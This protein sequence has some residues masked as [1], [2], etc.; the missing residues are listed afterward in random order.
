MIHFH[1]DCRLLSDVVVTS[2]PS[3]EG[4]PESLDYLPG[5]KFLGIVAAEL[6]EEKEPQ[7]TLDLFHN[8]K[9]C[10][11]DAHPAIGGKRCLKMPLVWSINK[12]GKL[13]ENDVFQHHSIMSH[14]ALAE[15][16]IQLKQLR[17]SYFQP[18][19][20]ECID[21]KQTFRIKSA[22]DSNFR[23][24]EDKKMYGYYALP[25]GSNW[26]F[27]VSS[28]NETLLELV[29]SKLEGSKRIG[30]SRS[31]EYG[32]VSISFIEKMKAEP[33]NLTIGSHVLYLDSA[34]CLPV[35]FEGHL[36]CL[37]P[38]KTVKVDYAKSQIRTRVYQSWNRRR[39][40]L[41]A[42]RLI[43]ERGSVIVLSVI[44]TIDANRIIGGIGER[45]SEGFGRVLIDP[46][47]FKIKPDTE[48]IALSLKELKF[49]LEGFGYSATL[50]A[51]QS[52]L[53]KL[54][55][56]RKAEI[57]RQLNIDDAVNEF[58]RNYGTSSHFRKTTASQWGT[59]RSFAKMFSQKEDLEFE[60]FNK[61]PN[62]RGGYMEKG[63]AEEQW[64][65]G[66]HIIREV[67]DQEKYP[68]DIY[69]QKIAAEMAKL[70]S[71]NKDK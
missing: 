21:F 38:S 14:Q 3:T 69:L 7:R 11:G 40:A 54:L 51:I 26:R 4:F 70:K 2:S 30:R 17:N 23:R 10:F 16:G 37:F 50:P 66:K 36:E 41:D 61:V 6:Y 46:S 65:A 33:I 53:I 67:L 1:F 9:V 5:A 71:K 15:K 32:L 22:Y 57:S 63:I 60:L 42:D 12:G 64:R 27:T 47:F 39:H 29:K 68:V 25:A 28:S 43:L 18:E 8:G 24:S 19:T 59:V 31:A 45:V 48:F 58:V 13:G 35:D 62:Q 34:I 44:G 49:N 56:Q 20:G 55:E 52:Q